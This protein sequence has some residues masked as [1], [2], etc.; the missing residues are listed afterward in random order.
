VVEGLM[1]DEAVAILKDFYSKEN[2]KYA[3]EEKRRKK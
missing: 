3:P 2:V 1:R